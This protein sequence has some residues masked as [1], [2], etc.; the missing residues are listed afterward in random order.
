MD[1]KLPNSELLFMIPAEYLGLVV[2]VEGQV[3]F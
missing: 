2:P 1:L 3:C